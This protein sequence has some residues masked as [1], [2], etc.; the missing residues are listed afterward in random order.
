M[1]RSSK[2]KWE[3]GKPPPILD[4]HSQTKHQLVYDYFDGIL[5]LL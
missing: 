4:E 1:D 2:Y 5:K 3:L